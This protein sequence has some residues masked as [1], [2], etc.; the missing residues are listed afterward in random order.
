MDSNSNPTL[1]KSNAHTPDLAQQAMIFHS[2]GFNVIPVGVNKRPINLPRIDGNSVTWKNFQ[3]IQQTADQVAGFPWQR[4]TGIAAI[5]GPVSGDAVAF[6]FDATIDDIQA[7]KTALQAMG[8]PPEYPWVVQSASTTGYHIWVRCSNP[9]N[10]P[11]DKLERDGA[12]T[13]KIELRIRNHYTI[14]PGSYAYSQKAGRHGHYRFLSRN[15][16]TEAPSL[17]DAIVIMRAYDLVTK[18]PKKK[19]TGKQ[20]KPGAKTDT[21]QNAYANAALKDELEM[22]SQARE[23]ERNNQLNKSAFA[24]GQLIPHLL[25]RSVVENELA[26]VARQ[27]GLGDSEVELTIKSGIDAA[28]KQPRQPDKLI[29]TRRNS[30]T[31]T[32]SPE[33]TS[34]EYRQERQYYSAEFTDMYF[35]PNGDQEKQKLIAN[36]RAEISREEIK[37]DGTRFFVIDADSADGRSFC[38]RIGASDFTDNRKLKA[39]FYEA[40]GSRVFIMPGMEHHL[41]PAIQA[42]TSQDCVTRIE[43]F[44]RTGWIEVE[45]S[46]WFLIPGREPGGYRLTLS[47]KLPYHLRRSFDLV[48]ALETLI[49]SVGAEKTTIPLAMIFQAPLAHLVGWQNERYVTF[50]T[51]PT[52]SFKTSVAQLLLSIYGSEFMDDQYLLKMGNGATH[53]ALMRYAVEAHDLPLLIDNYKPNTG[54]GKSD[55]V[56]LMHN[57]VEGGNKDRLNR[58]SELMTPQ[59]IACWLLM[60]GEDVPDT[61]AAALARNLIVSFDQQADTDYLSR[62]QAGSHHLNAIGA[63]WLDWLESDDVKPVLERAKVMFLEHRTRWC[64]YLTSQQRNI[65]NASRIAANLASNEVTWWV[66][67]QH[68]QLGGLAQ[69]YEAAH[70]QG[71]EEIANSMAQS[72]AEAVE[73]TRFLEGISQLLASGKYILVDY[74]AKAQDGP[75][76]KTILGYQHSDGTTYILVNIAVNAINSL[77][78]QNG[79]NNLSTLTLG[80]QL[81]T[82][83]VLKDWQGNRFQTRLRTSSG[84]PYTFQLKRDAF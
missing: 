35:H 48:P 55:F 80:K 39:R 69:K 38:L 51:G 53:N 16:P 43:H 47:G 44:D 59:S 18:V 62:A 13:G 82:L 68:P 83:D 84:S 42:L 28:M 4:A 52:G 75:S 74:E 31:D 9:E 57:I 66:L 22:L 72:T 78:E 25:T 30:M 1:E 46:P 33:T 2:L 14:L 73:A 40:G 41:R 60:T 34:E 23:G 36:F 21:P 56:A 58:N 20:P 50:I 6:D 49:L 15:L 61:D 64:T 45:G 11:K 7:V 54:K 17:V 71:L 63:T 19:K 10:L 29:N 67:T 81:H 26:Q 65:A 70:Q 5:S 79:L 77:L 37:E 12:S 3:S 24:L 27:I 8:L 32:T 76:G